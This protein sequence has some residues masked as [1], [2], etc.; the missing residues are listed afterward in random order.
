M[1]NILR[2]I[3]LHDAI[4]ATANGPGWPCEEF[5]TAVFQISG[6][7]VATVEFQG[8]V[9]ETNWVAIQCVNQNTGAVSTTATAAGLYSCSVA[10]LFMVR[11]VVT[12]TSGTSITVYVGGSTA[13]KDESIGAS[14][15][16]GPNPTI[17]RT[18]TTSAD[19]STAAAITASPESGKKIVAMDILISSDTEMSFII[20]EETSA[21]GFAKVFLPANGTVQVTLR[22]FLKAAVADKKL[23]GKAS[24][25]GN[26]AITAVYFSEA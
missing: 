15:D 3:K 17:T 24:A 20:Q 16:S 4:S 22:G 8:M 10:G 14:K 26:V 2:R 19:M 5:S 12:W 1:R 7:F 21:T 11:A 13:G 23:Y 9:D 18:Y 6:T 25:S